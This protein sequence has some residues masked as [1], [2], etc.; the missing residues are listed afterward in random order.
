MRRVYTFLLYLLTPFLLVRL[1]LKGRRLPAYR[2]RLSER[3]SLDDRAPVSID[4]WVHAVSLGEVMAVSPLVAAL[5]AKQ[6]RVLI[7]TMTPT[8]SQQVIKRFGSDVVHQYIPYDLPWALRRFFK[9]YKPRLGIIMETELWP[10]LIDQAKRMELPLLLLNARL[11][12]KAFKQ[13]EKVAFIFKP[14]LNQFTAIFAQ[15]D[16]DATR[17]MALGASVSSVHMLG[18]MKFDV[19][20]PMIHKQECTQLKNKWGNERTVI[21][22]ASTHDDEESQLLTHLNQLKAAIPHVLLLLVPRHPERFS[23]VYQMSVLHGFKTGL[24]SEPSTI[25][26]DSD[27]VIVDSLGELL[28]FYQLSDYAF[29]GGSLV[30]VGGHNVLEPIAMQVPVFCGPYMHNSKSICQSLCA[31]GALVMVSNIEELV[32]ALS[33]MHQNDQRR[34]QQIATASAVLEANRGTVARY[35]E[36]IEAIL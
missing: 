17:F 13:Y 32:N 5:L 27:V 20:T 11:S 22:A 30:P 28:H 31:A 2:Q 16:E 29:V 4:V 26:V 25:D 12:D 18:N 35:M 21:I 3:F 34:L 24:R 6:L 8:G 7:T 23:A 19:Q 36:T 33:V 9:K 1:Y 10:N 14:V 15:S